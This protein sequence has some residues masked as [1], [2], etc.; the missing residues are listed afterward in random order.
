M[1]LT[2]AAIPGLGP[3]HPE[4]PPLMAQPGRPGNS[5]LK[6]FKK[7]YIE[8]TNRC[9]LACDFCHQ[10]RRPKAMMAPTTFAAILDRVRPH[11]DHLSLH[12]LGE[13]LLHPELGELLDLCQARGLQVNLTTNGTL[14]ARQQEMLLVSRALRQINISLHSVVALGT[15]QTRT[16][17]LTEVLAFARRA[18]QES[19]I[20]VNLRLWNTDR[21]SEPRPHATVLGQLEAFF[22]LNGRLAD[23][24]PGRGI[25]LAPRIFLSLAERFTWPHAATTDLG[26][27]G[28]CRGLLDHLAILV[29]GT[30]VP[31]CLDGEGDMALGNLHALGLPEI[32]TTPR[33][34]AMLQ[35]FARQRVVEP[36]C[37][38]C[39]YRLRFRH[40]GSLRSQ[41]LPIPDS[42][43]A[44]PGNSLGSNPP[45]AV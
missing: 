12:V 41:G 45:P 20:H 1:L 39:D 13:P 18:S 7:I 40:S 10:G 28:R 11:T 17:Y 5:H 2:V 16:E 30:V 35:G 3:E 24:P 36:L 8:I 43:S 33:A 14:L 19:A 31:C 26:D 29:D 21:G 38:R 6:K 23:A 15:E 25:T 44:P 32:L 4:R 34:L 37:R 22:G 27:L 9:N 42:V